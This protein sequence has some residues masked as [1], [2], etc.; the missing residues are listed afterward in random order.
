MN[1]HHYPAIHR[2]YDNHHHRRHQ[3]RISTLTKKKIRNENDVFY[4]ALPS[5]ITVYVVVYW[6]NSVPYDWCTMLKHT[7]FFVDNFSI[8]L[9]W[10]NWIHLN[11]ERENERQFSTLKNNKD[12]SSSSSTVSEIVVF[13]IELWP[14]F[15]PK[16]HNHNDN[17]AN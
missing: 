10:L 2:T 3:S 8:C 16:N 11:I 17:E 1:H 4:C 13:K 5:D 15:N 7:S 12:S 14:D 9:F 6:C